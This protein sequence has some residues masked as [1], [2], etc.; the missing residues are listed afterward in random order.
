MPMTRKTWVLSSSRYTRKGVYNE[1]IYAAKTWPR[2][3]DCP[4]GPARLAQA[5]HD[6][7]GVGGAFAVLFFGIKIKIAMRRNATEKLLRMHRA[8]RVAS[9][10]V[11][12]VYGR[13]GPERLLELLPYVNGYKMPGDMSPRHY[14]PMPLA[15]F[16]APP[17]PLDD[18]AEGRSM[19]IWLI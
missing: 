12:E 9:H 10:I 4:W 13:Y 5:L 16:C 17:P 11:R 7:I 8:T 15:K 3:I 14:G 6:A 2:W 1:A 19:G 18:A